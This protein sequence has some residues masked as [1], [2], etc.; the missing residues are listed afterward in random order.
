MRH[1]HALGTRHSQ[2][3]TFKSVKF[4]QHKLQIHKLLFDQISFKG[5]YTKRENYRTN[6]FVDKNAKIGAGR[7]EN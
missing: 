3:Q 7:G 2:C 5:V 1:M 4:G 6:S